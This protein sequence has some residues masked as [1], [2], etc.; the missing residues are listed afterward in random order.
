MQ[1]GL[2]VAFDCPTGWNSAAGEQDEATAVRL[3]PHGELDACLIVGTQPLYY[4]AGKILPPDTIVDEVLS[5]QPLFRVVRRSPPE[6][7][8]LLQGRVF[9]ARIVGW[10]GEPK[11]AT[12]QL[13]AV[14]VPQSVELQARAAVATFLWYTEKAGRKYAPQAMATFRSMRIV[15]ES[16]QSWPPSSVFQQFTE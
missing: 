15:A 5:M 11:I 7:L 1:T 13:I 10:H 9:L 12:G 16:Q 3:L 6:Q 8:Q 14:F 2:N 4:P